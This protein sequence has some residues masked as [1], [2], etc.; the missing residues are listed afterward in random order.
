M[1]LTAASRP[2]FDFD[3]VL[4]LARTLDELG[5]AIER[6]HQQRVAERER[7]YEAWNGPYSVAYGRRAVDEDSTTSVAIVALWHD[8]VIWAELWLSEVN[9]LNQVVYAEAVEAQRSYLRAK[10]QASKAKRDRDENGGVL[11]HLSN[12]TGVIEDA[13][14]QVLSVAGDLK[15]HFFAPDDQA[16]ASVAE[17]PPQHQRPSS[18]GFSQPSSLFACYRRNGD[19][20]ILDWGDEIPPD[21]RNL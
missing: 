21:Q 19:H 20:L 18:P 11:G 15:D 5:H 12:V 16:L 2:R 7:A 14:H 3:G 4:R 6:S 13:G 10:E 17:P 9:H 8:A 1:G